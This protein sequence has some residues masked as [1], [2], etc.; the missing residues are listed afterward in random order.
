ML[1][2]SIVSKHEIRVDPDKVK[3]T[4]EFPAP[5]SILQLQSLQ[6]KEK[7]LRRF[8]VNYADIMKGF[9]Q[10]LK[11]GTLYLWDDQAQQSFDAL[12]HALVSAPLLSAP[13]YS[14]DF[15]LYLAASP[16]S[17]GM[18]LVQVHDDDSEHVIYYLSKGLIGPELHYSHVE[19]LSLAIVFTVT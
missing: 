8:I 17:L 19:K 5:Q 14:R 11:K 1:F 13:D 6:G 3:A 7:F 18:V 12:K 2:R 15:L 9:M 10:L 16:S 4:V